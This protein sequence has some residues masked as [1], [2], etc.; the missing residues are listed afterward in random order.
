MA[1]LGVIT[2]GQ[3][4]RVDMVPE[5]LPHWPGVTVIERGALDGWTADDIARQPI[6][7]GD[8]VLTSRLTDGGSAV[9][10]RNLV[11]PLI[12]EHI[13]ALEE[14]CVDAT[15]LLCTGEFPAFEHQRPLLKASPLVVGGLHGLASARVGV[16]CPLSE[17]QNDSMAKFAP[18]E[19]VTAVANPYGGPREDFIT[20]AQHLHQEGVELIM[21]DCMGYSEQHR[22]WIREATDLPVIVARSMVAHLVAEVVVR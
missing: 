16:I 21:L 5:M 13:T 9:F 7:D 3:A 10:G 6:A 22:A 2:I 8:E 18:L 4:P 12:Q 14:E 19:V 1:T 17:Q 11:L 15:L 20:A